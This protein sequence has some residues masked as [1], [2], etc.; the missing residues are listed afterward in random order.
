[1]KYNIIVDYIDSS[2]KN[3][4]AKMT[5]LDSNGKT[6]MKNAAISLPTD[7][8]DKNLGPSYYS[9]NGSEPK[10]RTIDFDDSGSINDT[11]SKNQ[12]NALSDFN[13]ENENEEKLYFEKENK[14]YII[15]KRNIMF[16]PQSNNDKLGV[17]KSSFILHNNDY[18]KIVDIFNDP[19]LDISFTI[20]KKRFALFSFFEDRDQN[21]KSDINK[22]YNTLKELWQ[23]KIFSSPN[24]NKD[25]VVK[26]RIK[27]A[28]KKIMEKIIN[29]SDKV[30]AK[31]INSSEEN[32]TKKTT[33]ESTEKDLKN[34]SSSS[35]N[36]VVDK[37]KY[38]SGMTLLVQANEGIGG[39]VLDQYKG[40][41]FNRLLS[42]D[43]LP[44]FHSYFSMQGLEINENNIRKSLKS[45]GG[46]QPISEIS[47]ISNENGF[48]IQLFEDDKKSKPLGSLSFD[49]ESGKMTLRNESSNISMEPSAKNKKIMSLSAEY[50]NVLIKG[51]VL[52][53][54]NSSGMED[55]GTS[56]IN[57][58]ISSDGVEN[59]ENHFVYISHELKDK[60]SEELFFM[61]SK[62]KN[63]KGN[64]DISDYLNGGLEAVYNYKNIADIKFQ[65][66][67][68]SLFRMNKENPDVE[69]TNNDL[70]EISP[71]NRPTFEKEV[72]KAEVVD[73]T[74][75]DSNIIKN[76]DEEN[77]PTPTNNVSPF[78]PDYKRI[79]SDDEFDDISDRTVGVNMEKIKYQFLTGDPNLT[80]IDI[81][82][83]EYA[84][85]F[86]PFK[87]QRI[88]AQKKLEE[89]KEKSMQRQLLV[90][91]KT[92]PV[93]IQIDT[94]MKSPIE[95]RKEI[96][97]SDN[98]PLIE[99]I[100]S[101]PLEEQVSILSKYNKEERLNAFEN[102]DI[103]EKI[104][105]ENNISLPP[106]ENIDNQ[107]S[108][109]SLV[110]NDDNNTTEVN[111][112]KSDNVDNN[113]KEEVQD[114][115]E[116]DINDLPPIEQGVN[117]EDLI[118][119]NNRWAAFDENAPI[120]FD[121][122]SEPNFEDVSWYMDNDSG[123]TAPPD[124]TPPP[125]DFYEDRNFS[126]Q[127]IHE[128]Q[129]FENCYPESMESLDKTL[130]VD[131]LSMDK[132]K[133]LEEN[134]KK[135]KNSPSLGMKR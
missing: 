99:I 82:A 108:D 123:Q 110:I 11:Y 59:N 46:G 13:E 127:N 92:Q 31:N 113:V 14:N 122:D 26:E 6:I 90:A 112:K 66:K 41:N 91:F 106:V 97:E 43:F 5:I 15:H 65:G 54:S 75:E 39:F 104:L 32:L 70:E 116:P 27:H 21:K 131:T 7:V 36:V 96:F 78:P 134:K 25:S 73:K 126:D 44:K 9:L 23:K 18:Q 84:Y 57:F 53:I 20:Q 51:D 33:I 60:G 61:D 135:T 86:K 93:D 49:Y 62:S 68:D 29:K 47:F 42:A 89:D 130:T 109:K 63:I 37:S 71:D 10:I 118:P 58:N 77:I 12:F 80:K 2:A 128:P 119:G 98:D 34:E 111:E 22:A 115:K 133:Q 114:F 1:M 76:V 124:Y 16:F 55:S 120:Q 95:K 45:I 79:M 81:T 117:S 121:N 101:Q 88:A 85:F 38:N 94:L 125:I 100:Y 35:P 129:P 102:V 40:N 69:I 56:L 4:T 72:V 87:E 52:N 103:L 48:F 107:N 67:N 64:G 50:D 83:L 19:E 74:N 28:S 3:K 30:D 24:R 105:T 17:D 8:F 132:D